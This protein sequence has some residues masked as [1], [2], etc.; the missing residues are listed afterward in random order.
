MGESQDER[1]MATVATINVGFRPE[2]P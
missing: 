1:H 2:H